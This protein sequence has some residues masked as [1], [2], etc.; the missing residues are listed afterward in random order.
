MSEN[1][2]GISPFLITKITEHILEKTEDSRY[3]KQLEIIINE[4]YKNICQKY[5]KSALDKDKICKLTDY[6][7]IDKDKYEIYKKIKNEQNANINNDE[8]L[9]KLYYFLKNETISGLSKEFI[10]INKNICNDDCISYLNILVYLREYVKELISKQIKD[11]EKE[12]QRLKEEQLLKEKYNMEDVNRLEMNKT[13]MQYYNFNKNNVSFDKKLIDKVSLNDKEANELRN[14][15]NY[16]LNLCDDY[17][18]NHNVYMCSNLQKYSNNVD[19]NNIE[20]YNINVNEIRN[21]ILGHTNGKKDKN[22]Q[23]EISNSLI[24]ET[25][26]KLSNIYINYI[27]SDDLNIL[28]KYLIILKEEINTTPLENLNE[29]KAI[30]NILKIVFIFIYI[31][32]KDTQSKISKKQSV[33]NDTRNEKGILLCE[34]N[35]EDR[36]KSDYCK[37]VGIDNCKDDELLNSIKQGIKEEKYKKSII[38]KIDYCNI[39]TS[40]FKKYIIEKLYNKYF[41]IEKININSV[42]DILFDV[43]YIIEEKI[44]INKEFDYYKLKNELTQ[45]FYKYENNVYIS[46]SNLIKNVYDKYKIVLNDNLNQVDY[47]NNYITDFLNMYTEKSNKKE[48]IEIIKISYIAKNKNEDMIYQNVQNICNLSKEIFKFIEQ[49]YKKEIN[50]K[51]KLNRLCKVNEEEIDEIC[52]YIDCNNLQIQ[53]INKN[54][55]MVVI[56]V[57]DTKDGKQLVGYDPKNENLND[58]I[59]DIVKFTNNYCEK[60]IKNK[61]KFKKYINSCVSK[62]INV[63]SRIFYLSMNDDIIIPKF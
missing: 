2:I 33:A 55:C 9:L 61:Q 11:K 17:S 15:V 25:K 42:N 30:K 26:K 35:L 53:D 18:V 63:D 51:N 5:E 22:N 3:K 29:N 12:E 46:T 8:Y 27:E 1:L 59:I 23:N 37:K 40:L 41:K 50:Y 60:D 52:K 7:H 16:I 47:I 62:N 36:N 34:Y 32:Q 10:E 20:N 21:I 57:L 19:I 24:L 38:N 48:I 56:S 13:E 14:I 45:P 49:L 31:I 39:F 4:I 28:T 6:T 54:N 58:I 44:K 43:I